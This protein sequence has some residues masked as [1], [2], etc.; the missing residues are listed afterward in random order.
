MWKELVCCLRI[1]YKMTIQTCRKTSPSFYW[2]LKTGHVTIS[3]G[4]TTTPQGGDVACVQQGAWREQWCTSVFGVWRFVWT[5]V[6]LRITTQKIT[7]SS[8]LHANSWSLHHNVSKRAWTFTRFLET[9]L[10]HYA[11]RTL[12]HFKAPW[13]MSDS[14]PTNCFVSQIYPAWFSKY[15]DFSKSM[16]K[17]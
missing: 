1:K 2:H 7:F 8:V 5:E 6:V 10:L 3:T 14:F 13:A 4:L 11:I 17:I 9:Y 16:S 15:S 12:Q